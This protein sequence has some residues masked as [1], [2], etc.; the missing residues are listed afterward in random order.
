MR[1]IE[2]RV[3]AGRRVEYVALRNS[4]GMTVVEAGGGG[5]E[6]AG[7]SGSGGSGVLSVQTKTKL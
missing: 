4:S 7:G 6:A 2:T 1:Q 5:G 3:E